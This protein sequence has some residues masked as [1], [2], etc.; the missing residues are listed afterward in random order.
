MAVFGYRSR[1]LAQRNFRRQLLG[2][3]LEHRHL[4]ASD[5]GNIEPAPH[6]LI[7]LSY[8]RGASLN[9]FEV[10]EQFDESDHEHQD[11]DAILSENQSRSPSLQQYLLDASQAPRAPGSL[12]FAASSPFQVPALNSLPGASKTLYL[13]FD[14]HFE[15][16]WGAYTN[17][18]SPAFDRDGNPT[19]L[20]VEELQYIQDVWE[21]V[22]EDYAPFNVNVT[23]IEPAVLAAGV[24]GD[25][26]NGVALRIAI[27]GTDLVLGANAGTGLAGMALI[28]SFT[29][30]SPNVAFVFPA[31]SSGYLREASTI[32]I[33]V[34]HEAG[35]SYGLLHQRNSYDIT[36]EWQGIMN[37]GV[38]G[39]DDAVWVNGYV[40]STSLQDDMAMLSTALG[41]RPDD[42]GNTITT[43]T[44][45]VGSGVTWSG[46]GLVSTTSDV[47]VWSIT[48]T[49]VES[50]KIEL[51]GVLLGQNLDA[52]LE[53]LDASGN[54]LSTSNP[55]TS[56]DAVL[57]VPVTANTPLFLRVRSTGEYGRVGQYSLTTQPSI[58]GIQLEA[59]SL[60]TT[61]E[62]GI[63]DSASYFLTRQ[64]TSNVEIHFTSQNPQEG[65]L[66]T[67]SVVFTPSNWYLP[68]TLSIVGTNDAILDGPVKY[69]ITSSIQS[70]DPSYNA[71]QL[72]DLSV[73]NNDNE[74]SGWARQIESL[75]RGSSA[76]TYDVVAQA[77]GSSIVVGTFSGTV[78]FDPSAGVVSRT[79]AYLSNLFLAKYTANGDLAWVQT[80][81][82][83]VGLV[84]PRALLSDATGNLYVAATLSGT[85]VVLGTITLNSVGSSDAAL[86]KFSSTGSLTWAIN[87]G[88]TGVDE[89]YDIA[90]DSSGNLLVLGIYSG[91]VDFNPAKGT[92]NRTSAGGYD[93]Y[94]AKFTSN[95]TFS[96]VTTYGGANNDY[97]T[98]LQVDASNQVYVMGYFSTSTTIGSQSM[99]SLGAS[100]AFLAKMNSTGTVQWVRQA[101]SLDSSVIANRL[102][103][104]PNGRIAWTGELRGAM[105]I[106]SN[107]IVSEDQYALLL[108]EWDSSGNLVQFGQMSS[109]SRIPIGDT[110]FDTQGRLILIGSLTGTTDLA[111]GPTTNY[112]TPPSPSTHFVARLQNNGLIDAYLMPSTSTSGSGRELALDGQGNLILAGYLAD[113][114]LAPSGGI[115]KNTQFGPDFYLT[116]IVLNSAPVDLFYDSFEVSEWNGVW[117]EDSQNDWYWSTQRA[118]HGTR[119]AEVDGP[120]TNATLSLA[121]PV[122]V[123]GYASTTLTF[124]WMIESGF[125]T[126]EFLALDVS[127]NNGATWIQDV[128]R[129]NGNVSAENTWIRETV[130]LAPYQSTQFKIRFRSSVSDSTEDANVDNVR[131]VGMLPATG[132]QTTFQGSG[133]TAPAMAGSSSLFSPSAPTPGMV[134]GSMNASPSGA[135]TSNASH[136]NAPAIDWSMIDGEFLEEIRSR[137]G[138]RRNAILR[139]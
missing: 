117:V 82:N 13:D 138:S 68:Q 7:D 16:T 118:T 42:V 128:R 35:H 135:S 70:S 25:Q 86:L 136:A 108:T 124:D 36:G 110:I 89:A 116:K 109:P 137:T 63:A 28:N 50:L 104:A 132:L 24:P 61:S 96:S 71:L 80:F 115:P 131:I 91:T 76:L 122:N 83:D 41:Y 26:A 107:S 30:T 93:G 72:V 48:P 46:Q 2:E 44:A 60:L 17:V 45:M 73:I 99:T 88:S 37:S 55:S 32:G 58:A 121:S 3:C 29:S 1:P 6:G 56:N 57:Y 106:G 51:S 65:T 49:Q 98:S 81:N 103:L 53:L 120:A 8:L 12:V 18:T 67:S 59:P 127:T 62:S 113:K 38:F 84:S 114:V 66:S 97:F 133:S 134:Q 20:S 119:S 85:N 21:I 126:G 78:D 33:T 77:D 111:P 139:V 47:D 5:L 22:A 112:A 75:S 54:V 39:F 69:T 15:A 95:G 130:D 101:A 102:A 23:T 52:I 11:D 105:T 100:D 34:S 74:L 129:L 40:S 123:T 90:F 79:A 92:T 43:A 19:S 94:L 9:A 31:S 10:S 4:M 125:D 87:W 14:G 27:G 64:P